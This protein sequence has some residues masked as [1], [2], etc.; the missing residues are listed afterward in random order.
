MSSRRL[1]KKEI[2]EAACGL[3]F[4]ACGIVPLRAV[5]NTTA[6]RYRHWIAEGHNAGMEYLKGYED[7]R[8]DPRL[9]LPEATSMICLA[10]SYVPDP[11]MP[12]SP[13]GYSFAAYALGKD[14]HDVMK[15]RMRQ[16]AETL[17][18][19]T[20]RVFCDTAPIM[21][22]Y[23]AWQAGIGW[24]GRN[25]QLIIPG[26]GSM[27]FLGEIVADID[28]DCYDTPLQNGCGACRR[29]IEACPTHALGEGE[30]G[31]DAALCLSYQTIEN[32][33][34]IPEALA[35]KMGDCIYGCD[36]CQQACPHNR[37]L[38]PTGIEEF[39]PSEKLRSMTR[40][41]W[42]NLTIEQYRALFKGSAVKRAKYEGLMRNIRLL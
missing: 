29:C 23:W 2:T 28:T 13:Q 10:M 40:I 31:F 9:L 3:G 27:F 42:Q 5:D 12:L 24:I 36:R 22:R 19:G 38:T 17:G 33:G 4:S 15:K 37:H 6:E 39:L 21:E 25:H 11:A 16:L 8:F 35:G 32:R 1:T 14:Y 30:D 34:D 7:V 41:Q 20:Y 18:I 26:A